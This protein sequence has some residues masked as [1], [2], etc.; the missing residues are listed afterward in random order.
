M[1]ILHRYWLLALIGSVALHFA[2]FVGFSEIT[3]GAVKKPAGKPVTSVASLA[4]VLGAPTS[5]HNASQA[6]A[7]PAPTP[8]T[9]TVK[10]NVAKPLEPVR[11][12]TARPVT[13]PKAVS[14]SSPTPAQ[15]SPEARSTTTAPVVA[16]EAAEAKP[17][18][19]LASA[20]PVKAQPTER[21]KPDNTT[22]PKAQP[23]EAVE[24]SAKRVPPARTETPP[25]T[26]PKVRP[27]RR[28]RPRKRQQR[29]SRARRAGNA[30]Q[31]AAGSSR[32]GRRG[33]RSASAGAVA[34]YAARVRARI[35]A[36]RPRGVARGRVVVS[37]GL[38]T[39][40]GLRYA[41]VSRSSGSAAVDRAAL[42]AVRRSSPF[43]RPPAGASSRQLRYSIA[44]T[45]R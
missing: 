32:G 27:K 16:A 40:G 15:S 30:R 43:P 9:K 33:R 13:S 34:S 41:R 3:S 45:F 36:N 2:L 39:G 22:E 29:S 17:V 31:G 25:K 26:T 37:F 7:D 38:S 44:F 19:R 11:T 1:T 8:P 10:P 28:A 6:T 23:A 5:S 20:A 14:A 4:G 35:L 24:K 18:E 12:A 21:T 42:A